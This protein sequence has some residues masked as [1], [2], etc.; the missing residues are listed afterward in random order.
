M[1]GRYI[2]ETEKN[3]QTILQQARG[4][5]LFIDEAYTLYDG[6]DDRKDFGFRAIECL[7]ALLS[8][9]EPDMLIILAGYEKEMNQMLKANQGLTGGFPHKF[10]FEDYTAEELLQIADH[11]FKT[12]EFVL[13]VPARQELTRVVTE[14]VRR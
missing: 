8:A 13:S 6:A 7:L 3:M 4:N 10:H 9:N 2:G 1:V 5:V 14:T 12:K 11:L